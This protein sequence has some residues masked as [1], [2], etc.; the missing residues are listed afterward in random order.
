MVSMLGHVVAITF[1]LVTTQKIL[2]VGYFWP[3][4][5]KDCISVVQKFYPCQIFSHK[6]CAH[7]ASLHLVV[8]VRPFT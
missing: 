5:F 2:Y 4:L 7:P 3:S 1:L 8:A 6:M